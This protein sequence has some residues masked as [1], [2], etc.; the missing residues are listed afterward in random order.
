MDNNGNATDPRADKSFFFFNNFRKIERSETKIF[1]RKFKGLLED[2]KAGVRLLNIQLNLEEK[3]DWKNIK[4][5]KEKLS[6]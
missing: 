6:R 3:Q 4:K 1:S 2:G 5:N